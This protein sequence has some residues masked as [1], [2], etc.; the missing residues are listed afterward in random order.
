VQLLADTRVK[1]EEHVEHEVAEV[2]VAQ[3]LIALAQ[4]LHCPL[5]RY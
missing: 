5:A 1:V 3:L 2:Q 4:E